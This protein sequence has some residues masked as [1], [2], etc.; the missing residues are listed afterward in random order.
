MNTKLC[1]K[2]NTTKVTTEFYKQSNQKDGLQRYCKTCKSEMQQKYKE[3]NKE[4]IKIKSKEYKEKNR[5][6]ILIKQKIYRDNNKDKA[7]EYYENN[8]EEILRKVREYKLA[9]IEIVKARAK[10]YANE[11][12]ERKSL[13]GKIWREKYNLILKIKSKEY[14]INNA[15][16]LKESKRRYYQENKDYI[17]K[18]NKDRLEKN[19]ERYLARKRAYNKTKIAKMS[20]KNTKM[21]RRA[22]F[23]RGDVTT[24]QLNNLIS[25]TKKCYWC[26]TSLKGIIAHVDHYKP[27]SKGGEHTLSNLVMSCPHCNHTKSNKD[28]YIFANSLGRLI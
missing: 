7:K 20:C 25:T 9:N 2:C 5:D 21:K 28:P 23:K 4:L 13:L 6:E 1:T 19:R 3:K 22:V 18:S 24:S 27:I 16:K 8:K 11:N 15:D 17:I 14:R 10:K 26:N 12:K